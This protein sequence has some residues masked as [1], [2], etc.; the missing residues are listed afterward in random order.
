MH[1]ADNARLEN[2]K[3]SNGRKIAR[4]ARIF[5][6]FGP[7]RSQRPELFHEK[8]LNKQNERKVP[9]KFEKLSKKKL[10]NSQNRYCRRHELLRSAIN[11]KKLFGSESHVSLFVKGQVLRNKKTNNFLILNN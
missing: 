4:M 2:R 1:V 3:S 9:E 6:I 5:T 10:K 11:M 7:K 8:L